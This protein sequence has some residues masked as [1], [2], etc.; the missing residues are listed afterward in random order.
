MIREPALRAACLAA[1]LLPALALPGCE[2]MRRVDL[3][4]RVFEPERFRRR[5]PPVLAMV[6]PPAAAETAG[7]PKAPLAEPVPEPEPV[8]EVVPRP[9]PARSPPPPPTAAAETETQR[10]PDP[11]TRTAFLIRGNPWIT[12]FWSELNGEQ[13]GRVARALSRRGGAGEASA[14]WDALGLD[15]RVQLVF[16]P[17]RS[18]R[19]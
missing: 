12:R 1:A 17:G 6:P 4:D 14:A 8:R 7:L 9:A 5:A 15:D 11:A 13:Q 19:G 10:A 3:L 16:G 2:A 18:A